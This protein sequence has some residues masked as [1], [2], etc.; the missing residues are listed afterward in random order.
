LRP[1]FRARAHPHGLAPLCCV[2]RSAALPISPFLSGQAFEPEI[3]SVMSKAFRAA[4]DHLG[5]HMHS[6][7]AATRLVAAKII[8]LVQRGVQDLEQLVSMT[9]E[10]FAA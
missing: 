5:L 10:E 4:C 9:I 6:D 8:E 1:E 3:I 2:E 7:D